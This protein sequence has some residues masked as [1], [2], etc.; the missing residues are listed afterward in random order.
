MLRNQSRAFMSGA[1][2]E[3]NNFDFLQS[4]PVPVPKK[5]FEANISISIMRL[6]KQW[7]LPPLKFNVQDAGSEPG[8]AAFAAESSHRS[9]QQVWQIVYDLG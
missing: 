5:D 6:I 1:G 7:I 4:L 3:L 9:G 8:T 2:S